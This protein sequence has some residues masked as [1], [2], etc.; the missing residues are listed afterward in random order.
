MTE[1]NGRKIWILADPWVVGALEAGLKAALERVP[2][3]VSCRVERLDAG[4]GIAPSDWAVVYANSAGDEAKPRSS[5][6]GLSELERVLA[7]NVDGLEKC[8]VISFEPQE[9]LRHDPCYGYLLAPEE[10]LRYLRLPVTAENMAG[11]LSS[12]VCSPQRWKRQLHAFEASKHRVEVRGSVYRHSHRGLRAAVRIYLGALQRRDASVENA[13]AVLASLHAKALQEGLPLSADPRE[14]IEALRQHHIALESAVGA[15]EEAAGSGDRSW[16]RIAD[17]LLCYTEQPFVDRLALPEIR[18]CLI[19]DNYD[20]LGWQDVLEAI[21][22]PANLHFAR[23]PDAILDAAHTS[24][25]DEIDVL[26]VDCRIGTDL[27]AGLRSIPG[28]RAERCDLPIAMV[29]AF[30][31][32]ELA[33]EALRSGCNDFFAKELGDPEDR[34]SLDYYFRLSEIIRRPVWERGLRELWRRFS[35]IEQALQDK[36]PECAQ[37]LREAFYAL[38][39]LADGN[40]WCLGPS[41]T[42]HDRH[43]AN[44]A[45]ASALCQ[46]ATLSVWIARER[47]AESTIPV[48]DFVGRAATLVR[49]ARH[50][51]RRRFAPEDACLA[52]SLLLSWLEAPHVGLTKGCGIAGA[53]SSEPE[54]ISHEDLPTTE[55]QASAQPARTMAAHLERAQRGAMQFLLGTLLHSGANDLDGENLQLAFL[56]AERDGIDA[57]ID[58]V[59]QEYGGCLTGTPSMMRGKLTVIDDE[60]SRS[61]WKRVAEIVLGSMG[62]ETRFLERPRFIDK[63]LAPGKCDAVLLDL[64]LPGQD[65]KPSPGVG[66]YA[67]RRLRQI[68]PA[69]PV[70]VLSSGADTVWALRC[71]RLGAIDYV[72]RWLPGESEPERWHRASRYLVNAILGAVELGRSGTRELWQEVSSVQRV[73]HAVGNNEETAR[74][75]MTLTQLSPGALEGMIFQQLRMSFM[76]YQLGVGETMSNRLPPP[77]DNWRVRRLLSRGDSY[78]VDAVLGAGRAVELLG[79]VAC[80][81]Y[82]RRLVSREHPDWA[83]RGSIE[84]NVRRAAG[85]AGAE[86]WKLR[87]SILHRTGSRQTQITKAGTER[88]LRDAV[89]AVRT[90]AERLQTGF[91][92]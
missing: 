42:R 60:A 71:L 23:T 24:C 35:L 29:T 58:F 30:D 27:L 88:A 66:L 3:L 43:P 59:V 65:E 6:W 14:V 19:D 76:L 85:K 25:V 46:E 7:R 61:G 74:E 18:L 50:A 11:S 52:M 64:W 37:S 36:S 51:A 13:E 38:F 47:A 89:A 5:R 44:A 45:I 12:F 4:V 80:C 1:A 55:G 32:A 73:L 79:W 75:L 63:T 84:D 22:P 34:D 57:A 87:N 49:D 69:L 91:G 10:L 72:V 83:A 17:D 20:S 56:C 70:L 48:G 54:R 16:Q 68:D 81:F 40:L 8:L 86:V 39:S 9:T 82:N 21:I 31:N 2:D 26:L 92:Q 15:L 33:K 62:V 90:F 78:F 28:L 77:V 67:L 53:V 41:G